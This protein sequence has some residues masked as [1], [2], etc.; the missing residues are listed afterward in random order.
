MLL[1]AYRRNREKLQWE[2]VRFRL[3]DERSALGVLM[4]AFVEGGEYA[5]ELKREILGI[6]EIFRG[7]V[8][9]IYNARGAPKPFP[10]DGK[11]TIL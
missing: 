4:I 8:C 3:F 1:A 6:F 10:E 11:T 2:R 7:P 5:L 9:T